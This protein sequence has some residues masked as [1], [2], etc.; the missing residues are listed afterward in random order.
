MMKYILSAA[1]VAALVTFFPTVSVDVHTPVAEARGGGHDGHDGQRETGGTHNTYCDI[2]PTC[3]GGSGNYVYQ[4]QIAPYMRAPLPQYGSLPAAQ[5][6]AMLVP[7]HH[8]QV[9]M[10]KPRPHEIVVTAKPPL[11]LFAGIDQL[12]Q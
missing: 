12:F 3:I 7:A 9:A 4:T 11:S 6:F 1:A 10:R 8:R 2:D 5:R